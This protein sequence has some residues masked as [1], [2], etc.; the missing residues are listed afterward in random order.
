MGVK[1]L[2]SISTGGEDNT[3]ANVGAGI[4]LIFRDK[5]GVIINFKSLLAGSGMTII[6][7]A[8]DI[9][10]IASGAGEANTISSVGGGTVQIVATVP[11]V[12]DDLRTKSISVSAPINV[13]DISDLITF[14]LDPLVNAD[15]AA[16]AL[17]S[18]SKL[19]TI[20]ADRL[21]GREA[22]TGVPVQIALDNT[23]ELVPTDVLRRPAIT[24]D[25]SIPI[26]SN[27]ATYDPLSIVDA[28]VS[29]TALILQSKLAPLVLADL[30]FGSAFQRYRTNSGATAIENFTEESALVF[31]LGDNSNVITTGV[32]MHLRIPFDC[33]VTRWT[34]LAMQSG[35]IVVDVNRF[36]SLANFDSD[37]KASITGT[38]T[39]DLV[40]DRGDESI[41]LTGWTVV[42]NQ[43]DILEAEVDSITTIERITLTLRVNKRG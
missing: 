33:E 26:N 35:S 30:P 3:G 5:T 12:G 43:G 42:L 1:G 10:L 28:D 39:P 18:L 29:L 41:A 7:N 21:I 11:K 36:T 8:D 20:F 9:E 23:L 19:Q 15:I 16:G 13:S 31:T 38:D 37:T 2:E 4:G 40:A 34:L 27:V 22:G 14:G 24:G 32:K 25:I 6:N 17:I